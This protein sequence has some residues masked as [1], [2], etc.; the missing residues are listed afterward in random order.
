MDEVIVKS[1][2]RLTSPAEEEAL[3]LWRAEAPSNEE[4]YETIVR[5][6]AATA[7]EDIADAP[8]RPSASSIIQ[9]AGERG[10]IT[11]PGLPLWRKP[12][13][14]MRLAGSVALA[15]SFV[16]GLLAAGLRPDRPLFEANEIKTEPGGRMTLSLNDGSVVRL[17]PG[18]SLRLEASATKRI[19]WLDG[20]AFFTVARAAD[21]AFV[22]RTGAG[23]VV[24]HGTRFQVTSESE[25][26][27]LEVLVVEGEVAVQA[28]AEEREVTGGQMAQVQADS[29]V[30]VATT[31]RVEERLGWMESF[32]V[33]RDTPLRDAAR[34]VEARFGV[35]VRIDD[36][37]PWDR[38]ITATFQAEPFQSV[39]D[40]ICH[41]TAVSCVVTDTLAV[42][43]G[44]RQ[45]G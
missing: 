42:I 28:G 19:V 20:R 41:A 29:T 16:G 13:S 36:S 2:R 31:D 32:L 15:A 14:W 18:S 25:E 39:V 43:R 21:R 26:G 44:V 1:L 38:S 30:S 23:E 5:I 9:A 4:R 27:G 40:V 24:V 7:R 17:A 8:P 22:V 33:F 10:L 6:W 35:P 34:E 12:S 3:R 37:V 11:S 45:D